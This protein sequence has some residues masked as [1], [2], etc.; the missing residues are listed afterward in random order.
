MVR[1]ARSSGNTILPL[2]FIHPQ[3]LP[4]G[5]SICS[6]AKDRQLLSS[7]R[8]HSKKSSAPK[9]VTSSMQRRHL[10]A[11]N[12]IS[13][14]RLISGALQRHRTP[15][16]NHPTLTIGLFS[17]PARRFKRI[18][19]MSIELNFVDE[20]IERIG[21]SPDAVIP[22]LQAMQEHYGY[23]P[24]SALSRVCAQTGIT[25]ASIRGVSS[26]YDM[27]RHKPAGQ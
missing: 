12:F 1:V 8:E 23:L 21:R 9:W 4:Q 25:P 10:L 11:I 3:R 15:K 22:I 24:E 6:V 13:V 19:L 7:R 27:F 2:T 20:T 14:A 17:R 18:A 5:I 16:F 26:F